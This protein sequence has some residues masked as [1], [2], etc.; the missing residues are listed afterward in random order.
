MSTLPAPFT[1][2]LRRGRYARILAV[3]DSKDK[4][5]GL[6]RNGKDYYN[7]WK[8]ETHVQ[9]IWRKVKGEG[10]ARGGVCFW[11]ARA[12][13]QDGRLLDFTFTASLLSSSL[14]LPSSL[15][16]YPPL[17]APPPLLPSSLLAPPTSL[18]LANRALPPIR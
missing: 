3:Y 18:G 6:T 17:L 15:P 2:V 1:A 8:D 14:L 7:F 12:G 4:I 5:P 13:Q 10:R 11:R 16:I 9:G